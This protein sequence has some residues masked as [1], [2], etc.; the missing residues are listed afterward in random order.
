MLQFNLE[1]I[2]PFVSHEF[3]DSE[4]RDTAAIPLAP[5]K[6]PFKEQRSFD[7]ELIGYFGRL[8]GC[9]P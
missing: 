5:T 7:F 6:K 8:A 4:H 3:G 9:F 1:R 2:S